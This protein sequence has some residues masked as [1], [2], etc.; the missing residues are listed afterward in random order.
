MASA[1]LKFHVFV[2]FDGTIATIDTTN[3][4][5]ARYAD[6][7]WLD[8]EEQ[9]KSGEIG[10]RECMRRQID[11]IRATPE[12]FDAFI[13][14]IEIDPAFPQFV[15]VCNDLGCEITVV[16][17]GLDRTIEQVMMKAGLDL[18][19]RANHLEWTG[20]D[21]WRLSFPFSDPAC[22]AR[23]GHCK[24]SSLRETSVTHRVVVGD[25]RSDFCMS[26]R[27]DLV[28]AKGALADHCR[29]VGLPHLPFTDFSAATDHLVDWHQSLEPIKA[30][31][32]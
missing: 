11:L 9:W 5:L 23:A 25:G 26:Q 29:S 4:L 15:E 10:S 21:R 14:G 7:S 6:D 16:S 8:I 18:P 27:G 30:R 28:L 20:G 24:C 1:R 31:F 22:P 17:D 13:G 32:A 12:E 19:H 3:H 2:D